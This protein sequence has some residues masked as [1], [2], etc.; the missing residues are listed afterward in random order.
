MIEL[1]KKILIYSVYIFCACVLLSFLQRAILLP[2]R[3]SSNNSCRSCWH[4]LELQVFILH[5]IQKNQ[6]GWNVIRA[7]FHRKLFKKRLYS[8]LEK[9]ISLRYKSNTI[10]ILNLFISIRMWYSRHAFLLRTMKAKPSCYYMVWTAIWKI[11]QKFPIFCNLF[12]K[13]L[14]GWV[15]RKIWETRK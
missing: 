10:A 6:P 13:S 3:S 8:Y 14:G 2:N 11:I 1:D 5:K 4:S 9:S 15:N 7:S 12:Q